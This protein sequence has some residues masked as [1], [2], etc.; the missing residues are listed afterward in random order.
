MLEHG[1]RLQAAAR[2]YGIPAADWLDLSTGINPRPYPV[3]PLPT[4]VWQR[5]PE[6]ED[7]LAEAAAACYGSAELLPVA[8]SQAA[9]QALPALIPGARVTLLAPTYAEHPHAWRGRSLRRCRADEVDTLVDDTD[10][11]VLAHPNNPTGERFTRERLLGW[12][13]RLAARG[14][15]LVVDEA[16]IDADPA[17][18]LA[19]H[20]GRANLVVLRSLGKFFGLGGARAGFVLAEAA[21][22]ERLAE[23]LGPWAV[24]GPARFA[25]QAALA[26]AAWQRAA[27]DELA[28]A[29]RRLRELLRHHLPG[30]S[31]GTALFQWLPHPRAAAVH[32]ALARHGI[33]VRLF[34][35]PPALRFGLP[36]DEAGW[37][38]LADALHTLR[39]HSA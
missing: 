9:I 7:G 21:L 38:R 20:A 13:S 10:V 15:W 5:L 32:D 35:D 1:G 3:P 4:A 25:A 28:A 14:G 23:Q 12:H 2:R 11:L 18:S 39:G 26:D 8:G 33:L 31:S 27:R 37:R 24:S 30:E 34:D 6:D 36:A 29:G 16:F 22:R 17:E 19:P